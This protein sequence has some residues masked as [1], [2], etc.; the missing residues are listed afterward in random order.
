MCEFISFVVCED[1][2]LLANNLSAHEGIEALHKLKPGTY[3]ECEWT[4]ESEDTLTVRLEEGETRGQWLAPVLSRFSTRL[5]LLN[6]FLA[7]REARGESLIF[8][9]IE[10]AE[11]VVFP[12]S[13]EG[14]LNLNGLTSA[15]GL[16]LPKTVEGGLDLRGLTSAEGLVLPK[17]VGGGLD[18]RGLTS[19]KGLKLPK[20]VGGWLVLCGLPFSERKAIKAQGYKVY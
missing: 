16:V 12:E 2:R 18:L 5:E 4:G 11:G 13:V 7:H 19:A 14:S 1:G 6:W 10:S 20:T 8:E 9:G 15:E 3:R 17:K